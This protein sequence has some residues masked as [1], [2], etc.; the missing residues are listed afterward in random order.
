[1]LIFWVVDVVASRQVV[2]LRP[3]RSCVLPSCPCAAA[4]GAG[5]VG[6]VAHRPRATGGGGG[7]GKRGEVG[8][9]LLMAPPVCGVLARTGALL[10]LGPCCSGIA[11]DG[12]LWDCARGRAVSLMG[13]ELGVFCSLKVF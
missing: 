6:L 11:N 2:A 7:L 10:G 13:A 4:A 3:L 5:R 9:P 12:A 1:M 8:A